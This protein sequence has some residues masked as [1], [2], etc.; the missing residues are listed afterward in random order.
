M[1]LAKSFLTAK[2]ARAALELLNQTPDAQKKAPAYIVGRNWALMA[3]D[4]ASELRKSIDQGLAITKA[5]E[6]RYQDALL[7]LNQ[8]DYAGARTVLEDLMKEFPESSSSL[9]LLAQTYAVQG[10]MAKALEVVNDYSSRQPKSAYLKY[11]LGIWQLKAKQVG[12]ARQAFAEAMA[13]NPNYVAP[14]LMLSEMDLSDGSLDR[15]RRTLKEVL[16]HHPDNIRATF[17][18]GLVEDK[19]GNHIGAAQYYRA[20]L[21]RDSSNQDALNNLAYV[22]AA[23][24]PDEALQYAQQALEKAPENPALQDTIGWV[25]YRK[26]IYP[27]AL[28]YLKL[29]VGK[30][31]TAVRRYHLALAYAKVGE[32]SEA[33]KNL[34]AA[35]KLDPNVANSLPVEQ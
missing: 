25:Y 9:D 13:A 29:A 33:Q 18:L 22:L 14:A 20:V 19:S 15:A 17:L 28:N 35:L 30:E 2:D 7:R 11:S 4:N 24:H 16:S 1:D 6:L 5:P 32:R 12:L 23:D 8:K 26:G 10:N 34:A 27:T 21:E 3:L 31:A